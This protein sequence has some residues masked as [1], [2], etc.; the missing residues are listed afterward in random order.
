MNN[1]RPLKNDYG[2]I[3]KMR[4]LIVISLF[5]ITLLFV[6]FFDYSSTASAQGLGMND[7]INIDL[8]PAVPKANETVYVFLTSY[9]TNIDAASITWRVNGKTIKSGVGEK[10]FNFSMGDVGKITTLSVTVKTTD[11]SVIERSIPLKPISVDLVWQ[12][13][14]F[15]PPFYKGKALF[16]HQNQVTVIASPH[17]PNSSGGEVSPKNIIYKWRKNG[18]VDEGASG[19]GKNTYTFEGSLISRPVTIGVE[20]TATGG[21]GIGYATINLTPNEPAIIFYKKDP[22]YGIEFQRALAGTVELSNSNEINIIGAPF[23]YSTDDY[24]S[25]KLIY[26]WSINGS[27]INNAVSQRNQVLRQKEGTSGSSN[28]SLS[29]ENPGKILQYSSSNFYLQFKDNNQ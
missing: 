29:I 9:A 3:I 1:K 17:I 19:F 20:V 25:E 12:S 8:V 22:I 6:G 11:G 2:I 21:E 23:F 24:L 28:I 13:N 14:G 26:K 16:S 10:T 18:S 5:I 7:V 4:Y 15:V 27:P